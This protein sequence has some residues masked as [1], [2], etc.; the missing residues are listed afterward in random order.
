[1]NVVVAVQ[2]KEVEILSNSLGSALSEA[3]DS[4]HHFDWPLGLD[5]NSNKMDLV[6]INN[7]L[8]SLNDIVINPK[9]ESDIL[10]E[11]IDRLRDEII[12]L[13]SGNQRVIDENYKLLEEIGDLKTQ[14]RHPEQHST[15]AITIQLL[16]SKD[17]EIGKLKKEQEEK[18]RELDNLHRSTEQALKTEIEDLK[19]EIDHILKASQ[20]S[21]K[22]RTQGRHL[23]ENY[24]IDHAS[25]PV[26]ITITRD[27]HFSPTPEEYALDPHITH[28]SSQDIED[29]EVDIR[30]F[31][32]DEQNDKGED[33]VARD[34][35]NEIY[36]LKK[37]LQI[38]MNQ[39]N[40]LKEINRDFNRQ[41]DDIRNQER[42]D[43][44][45]SNYEDQL[46][47]SI[48][49]DI[50]Q[51]NA[52]KDSAIINNTLSKKLS[53]LQELNQR[54]KQ[55]NREYRANIAYIK[56]KFRKLRK[57]QVTSE[58]YADDKG[59]DVDNIPFI[60][61]VDKFVL[62][63]DTLLQ[64]ILTLT[65]DS[66]ETSTHI[67]MLN[68]L[69]TEL[70][71]HRLDHQYVNSFA[72]IAE[73]LGI[74]RTKLIPMLL[75]QTSSPETIEDESKGYAH[76][77]NKYDQLKTMLKTIKDNN[78]L[79][80][81]NRKLRN[82]L[83]QLD[84]LKNGNEELHKRVESLQVRISER[85]KELTKVK[86]Q[87][88]SVMST[89]ETYMNDISNLKSL[90]E[91]RDDVIEELKRNLKLSDT[92][93]KALNKTVEDKNDEID[94]LKE[95]IKLKKRAIRKSR[96]ELKTK[97]SKIEELSSH[98]SQLHIDDLS[99]HENVESMG[100][101]E[102]NSTETFTSPRPQNPTKKRFSFTEL[103]KSLHFS[104][105]LGST[106]LIEDNDEPEDDKGSSQDQETPH[107]DV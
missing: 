54:I 68:D 103:Y 104:K 65:R 72:D 84:V 9:A 14:I 19:R 42:K 32:L 73:R 100:Y 28:E 96:K 12:G 88:N 71:G 87:Y 29:I 30:E 55:E 36:H 105:F 47:P 92:K 86:S 57:T 31:V 56:E 41:L 79:V 37:E 80:H 27:E 38:W 23:V 1:M 45:E 5:L 107:A 10:E 77:R 75:N 3:D 98:M 63:S 17:Q 90:I 99:H 4:D 7:K 13:K 60:E 50:E 97:D 94:K 59:S 61:M 78:P 85:D 66:A 11:R 25:E 64:E 48:I 62:Y 82:E 15:A 52:K 49:D 20:V 35:P 81:E 102:H 6:N 58:L 93:I 22:T 89:M 8:D 44:D 34:I 53:K 101:D 51:P 67:G 91:E 40:D 33:A 106:D 95:L 69:L 24:D 83:D 39:V 74:D 18:L 43:Y 2:D 21:P 16:E 76:L 70:N 26:I 46:E